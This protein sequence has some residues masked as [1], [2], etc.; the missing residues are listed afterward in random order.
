[1]QRLVGVMATTARILLADDQRLVR[2]GLKCL[3]HQE[4]GHRVIGETGDGLRV[5]ALARRL[6]PDV[7]VL[8]IHLPGL[9]ALEVTRR[10]RAAVPSAGIVVLAG[11]ASVPH[12]LGALRHGAHGYVTKQAGPHEFLRAI[13]RAMKRRHYVSSPLSDV[14]L[15]RWLARAS[16]VARDDYDG[17][18]NREREVLQLVSE[19]YTSGAI[20]ERFAI[21]PR[22]VEAHRAAVMQKLRLRNQADLIRY[23]LARGSLPA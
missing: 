22:T 6:R 5:A 20:A 16:A 14:P 23:M 11:L 8:D 7:V 10:I 19:G 9:D 3:L 13:R 17:L 15:E 4:S 12:L 21:S 2:T 18:T 1:M